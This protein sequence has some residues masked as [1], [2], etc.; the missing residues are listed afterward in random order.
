[1]QKIILLMDNDASFL[2]TYARLLKEEGYMVLQA[3]TVEAAEALL[4]Q[5]RLHLGI[6]DIRMLDED[7]QNDLSGLL[8]AR[9]P[10]YRHLPKLM[11]TGYP[12]YEYVREAMGAAES[13]LPAAVNFIS[14]EEGP[15]KLLQAVA[16]AF[17]EHV[18]INPSL[19]IHWGE[20]P[21]SFAHLAAVSYPGIETHALPEL[22]GALEDLFRKLFFDY[23]QISFS[24]LLWH[25]P[26]R[27]AVEVLAYGSAEEQYVVTLGEPAALEDERSRFQH[28][29]PPDYSTAVLVNQLDGL[30]ASASVWRFPGERLAAA[31]PFPEFFT[32]QTDRPIR[33]ALE[34]LLVGTLS[35]WRAHRPDPGGRQTGLTWHPRGGYAEFARAAAGWEEIAAAMTTELTQQAAA[36][37]S[38]LELQV[39]G[40]QVCLQ[41]GKRSSLAC[42]DPVAYLLEE[43]HW[44]VGAA[45]SAVAMGMDRLESLLV[46]ENGRVL[47]TDHGRARLA[48]CGL[49]FVALE[50]GIRFQSLERANLLSLLDFEK[51]VAAA[52]SLLAGFNANS[53]EPEYRKAINALGVIRQAAAECCGLDLEAYHRLSL[54]YSAGELLAPGAQ[55]LEGVRLPERAV[56]RWLHALLYTA[57]L[58]RQ[59][60]G[61]SPAAVSQKAAPRPAGQMA[62]GGQTASQQPA[63]LTTGL[64]VD[65]V[66]REVWV[67][68]EKVSL[69]STEFDLLAYL[70]GRRG[71]ICTYREIAQA[72][73]GDA[74]ASEE[75]EKKRLTTHIYRLRKKIQRDPDN[76]AGL[77]NV[78]GAGYRL[79]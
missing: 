60:E 23:R 52:R 47:P 68:A 61:E 69:S 14:K 20:E 24:R 55:A 21:V 30:Q 2:D 56:L 40:G 45:K 49:D 29:A 38:G 67:G 26:G 46:S 62:G 43:S 33:L 54:L 76:H 66:R 37:R 57:L 35:C 50:A 39:A 32:R 79:E 70:E 73:F 77:V 18:R 4:Q 22:A 15:A 19:G 16:Q 74:A 78:P 75:D 41:F 11:L 13:A 71:Q 3:S 44:E 17:R 72:V 51:Q 8:L 53:V 10:A 25:N 48:P 58:C 5:R 64:R 65:R 1:M 7:D 31:L 27:S 9:N 59:M 42:P 28:L 12:S 36:Q 63:G 34:D 6:F